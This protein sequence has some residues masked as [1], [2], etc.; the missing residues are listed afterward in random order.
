MARSN[1]GF[2]YQNLNSPLAVIA[3]PKSSSRGAGH[4]IKGMIMKIEY[5][6]SWCGK[7][8]E[9]EIDVPLVGGKQ[10]HGICYDCSTKMDKDLDRADK[11]I[12]AIRGN[13]EER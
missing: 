5:I 8:W 13:D 1:R 3:L 10:T 11:L 4:F 9:V 7:K 6:C 2:L 12:R